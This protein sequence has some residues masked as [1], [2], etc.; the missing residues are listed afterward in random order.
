MED[1]PY[2]WLHY[3]HDAMPTNDK[4]FKRSAHPKAIPPFI[5]SFLYVHMRIHMVMVSKCIVITMYLYSPHNRSLWSMDSQGRVLR[6]DSFRYIHPSIHPSISMHDDTMLPYD[7][8]G[9]RW[10]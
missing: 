6:F 3:G 10:G 5:H 2:W 9:A 4:D 1:D 7:H 8:A